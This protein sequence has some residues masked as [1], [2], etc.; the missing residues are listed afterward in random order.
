MIHESSIIKH[1][2]SSI[3]H[4]SSTMNRQASIINHQ[5]PIINH[6]PSIISHQ[7]ST[8]NHQSSS[9]ANHDQS[10]QGKSPGNRHKS[11][12][13][14]RHSSIDRSRHQSPIIDHRGPMILNRVASPRRLHRT[15][16]ARAL[17]YACLAYARVVVWGRNFL[18]QRNARVP[19]RKRSILGPHSGLRTEHA[20]INTQAIARAQKYLFAYDDL[21][22]RALRTLKNHSFGPKN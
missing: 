4:Q 9:R 10:V 8:I 22:M 13:V 5:L 6:H 11:S 1:Q 16:Q 20:R 21:G 17:G 14:L 7:S 18:S 3:N 15:N 12:I 19:L 2:A